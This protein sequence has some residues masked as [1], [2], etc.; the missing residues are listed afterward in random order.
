MKMATAIPEY[1]ES[2]GCFCTYYILVFW[3][4]FYNSQSTIINQKIFCCIPVTKFTPI[5]FE[6]MCLQ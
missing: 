3:Y 6:K 4:D 5:T 1:L 2:Y